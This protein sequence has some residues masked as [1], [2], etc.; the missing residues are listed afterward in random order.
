MLILVLG[1]EVHDLSASNLA[2]A[3]DM[4]YQEWVKQARASADVQIVSNWQ[5]VVPSDPSLATLQLPDS[6]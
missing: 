1:R 6:K 4:R 2:R 5:D 3:R